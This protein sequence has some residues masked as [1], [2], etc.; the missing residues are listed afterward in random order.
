MY[1]PP[2]A[3]TPTLTAK[4]KRDGKAAIGDLPIDVLHRIISLTLDPRS[5]PSHYGRYGAFEGEEQEERVRRL[6]S[7]FNDLR[8]VDRRFYLGEWYKKHQSATTIHGRSS[9]L[10]SPSQLSILLS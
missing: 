10:D 6:W 4:K 8:R 3:Y 5:T 2:P 7:L 1:D 9:R